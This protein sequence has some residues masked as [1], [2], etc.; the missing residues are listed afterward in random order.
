M[1]SK[2]ARR[3]R[4]W[5]CRLDARGVDAWAQ[6]FVPPP[7]RDATLRFDRMLA[8]IAARPTGVEGA[9]FSHSGAVSELLLAS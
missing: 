7:S 1:R 5:P 8:E 2:K 3:S 6:A 9:A 4:G